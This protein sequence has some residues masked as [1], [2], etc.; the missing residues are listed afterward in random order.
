MTVELVEA[1]MLVGTSNEGGT[2]LLLGLQIF[3][4][5][6]RIS[7]LACIFGSSQRLFAQSFL[8]DRIGPNA[9]HMLPI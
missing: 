4:C 2:K 8:K 6:L 3:T 9:T 7:L 1:Y 5:G